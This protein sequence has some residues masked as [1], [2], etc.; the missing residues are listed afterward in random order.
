VI[1]KYSSGITAGA[2]IFSITAGPDGNLWFTE[3]FAYRA[4]MIARITPAGAVTEYDVLAP[5]G[6]DAFGVFSITAGSDG[7]LWFTLEGGSH[8]GKITTAGVVTLYN[9]GLSVGAGPYV[10]TAGPDR[11]LWFTEHPDVRIGKI[12]P[13]GV[14]TEYSRRISLDADLFGI[15]AGPGCTLWFTERSGNRIGRV[16]LRPRLCS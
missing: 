10:I 9:T 14:I 11:N 8:I 7:N 15:T 16:R 6:T 3:F 4:G 1:T 2:E 12:T 5:F 13:S